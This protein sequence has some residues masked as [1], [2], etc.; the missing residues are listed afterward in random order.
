MAIFDH[1]FQGIQNPKSYWPYALKVCD[2]DQEE[3][4]PSRYKYIDDYWR[5]I[6][7]LKDDE[8]A[9]KYLQLHMLARCILSLSHGNAVPER[10]FSING[11][12][13]DAHGYSVSEESVI[14]LR[15]G[16]LCLS[17]QDLYIGVL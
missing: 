16:K 8:G 6:G 17:Y 14:A 7:E 15:I 13:L 1:H 2:L 3:R 11:K 10:G 5:N 9:L 4:V 12:I